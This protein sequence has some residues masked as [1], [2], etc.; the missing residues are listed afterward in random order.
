[1]NQKKP[2]ICLI[3]SCSSGKLRLNQ[4]LL[5]L[6]VCLLGTTQDTESFSNLSVCFRNFVSQERLRDSCTREPSIG[7][8]WQVHRKFQ[9]YVV[10][11]PRGQ[12]LGRA[13]YNRNGGWG[14]WLRKILEKTTYKLRKDQLE[15]ARQYPAWRGK[16]NG[17]G[18]GECYSWKD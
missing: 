10:N 2:L 5:S 11:P 6:L 8:F 17:M 7:W 18:Q 9:F 3:C 4:H 13:R 1:M 16:W 15:I 12:H 14:V